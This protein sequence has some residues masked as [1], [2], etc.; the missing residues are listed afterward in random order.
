VL[1]F[2]LQAE[3]RM[4]CFQYDANI[5]PQRDLLKIGS[6][7]RQF[8]GQNLCSIKL[9]WIALDRLDLFFM[10]IREDLRRSVI[11]GVRTA[12]VV[13]PE[14]TVHVDG[15]LWPWTTR[16]M[17][18]GRHSKAGQFVGFVASKKSSDSGH[19][20]SPATVILKSLFDVC[21]TMERTSELEK[22]NRPCQYVL[23]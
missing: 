8:I 12:P 23:R 11:P 10:A 13:V 3:K 2:F 15:H 5:V 14:Y 19:P 9:L 16:L 20:R 22:G 4:K 6:V 1:P 7:A 17:S 21:I 18:H